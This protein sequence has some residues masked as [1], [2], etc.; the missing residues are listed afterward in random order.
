MADLARNG[1]PRSRPR[2]GKYLHRHNPQLATILLGKTPDE[3][4]NLHE[5]LAPELPD[6]LAP[7]CGL[8]PLRHWQPLE[9]MRLDGAAEVSEL[10]HDG[11]RLLPLDSLRGSTASEWDCCPEERGRHFCL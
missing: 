2:A 5:S 1:H 4:D 3:T 9:R 11:E 8:G 10:R 6:I 7:V